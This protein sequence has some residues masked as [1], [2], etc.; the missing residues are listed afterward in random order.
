MTGILN[1]HNQSQSIGALYHA[2]DAC[3]VSFNEGNSVVPYIFVIAYNP[4]LNSTDY[5]V[6]L[7]FNGNGQYWEE[8]RYKIN[9][10]E[11]FAGISL[12]SGGG[13]EPAILLLKQGAN[14]F[15]ATIAADKADDTYVWDIFPTN[16]NF[17]TVQF[18]SPKEVPQAIHYEKNNQKLYAAFH[19][20]STYGS[21]EHWVYQ[22][23]IHEY[24]NVFIETGTVQIANVYNINFIQPEY[25]EIEGIGFIPNSN[26]NCLLF[27][28]FEGSRDAGI[29]RANNVTR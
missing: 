4:D 18:D 24:D 22:N 1:P 17:T 28:T 23:H 13:S 6:K 2:N 3:I 14:Y 29:Y 27:S 11:K 12:L 9:N 19:I 20:E 5:I 10:N 7:G 15:C 21:N 16:Y 8:A 25:S 26:N